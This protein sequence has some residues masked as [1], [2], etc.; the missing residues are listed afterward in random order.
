V[1]RALKNPF[2]FASDASENAFR[3]ASSISKIQLDRILPTTSSRVTAKKLKVH[4][5]FEHMPTLGGSARWYE[6][7]SGILSQS[8][9]RYYELI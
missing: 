4:K 1:L 2:C 7:M 9:M 5:L 6:R 8:T 3:H